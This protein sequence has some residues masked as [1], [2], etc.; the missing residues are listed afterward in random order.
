MILVMTQSNCVTHFLFEP[1]PQTT[2]LTS[3]GSKPHMWLLMWQNVVRGEVHITDKAYIFNMISKWTKIDWC[4]VRPDVFK[5]WRWVGQ[6]TFTI[7]IHKQSAI[8][9]LL[10]ITPGSPQYRHF[11]WLQWSTFIRDILPETHLICPRIV[12]LKKVEYSKNVVTKW[13]NGWVL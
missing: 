3:V 10:N 12:S 4:S 1:H 6:Q 2:V 7:H 9:E 11:F 13:L 8:T 5:G